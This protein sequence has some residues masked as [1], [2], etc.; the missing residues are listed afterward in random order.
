VDVR[1][2]RTFALPRG[3]RVEVLAEAFNLFDR[4]NYSDVN[5]VFGPGAFPDQP[6]VDS[7]GRVT[8]GRYTKAYPP[9]QVQLAARVS[10]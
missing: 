7:A 5:N 10:F 9:R 8:Y 2:A 4:V 3:A 6:L 1:L